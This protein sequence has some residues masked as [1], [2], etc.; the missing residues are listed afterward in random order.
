ML[1]MTGKCSKCNYAWLLSSVQPCRSCKYCSAYDGI[2]DNFED[3]QS[4]E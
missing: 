3:N 4:E 1:E 2:E